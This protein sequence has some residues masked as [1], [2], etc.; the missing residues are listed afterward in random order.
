MNVNN[1]AMVK[2]EG[3]YF[4]KIFSMTFVNVITE[5]LIYKLKLIII[6]SKRQGLVLF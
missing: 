3:R 1:I 4:L 5:I 6:M 2:G